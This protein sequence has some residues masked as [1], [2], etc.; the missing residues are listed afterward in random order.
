MGFAFGLQYLLYGPLLG[1]VVYTRYEEGYLD[2]KDWC[3]T[4]LVIWSLRELIH[5]LWSSFV[6]MLFLSRSLRINKQGYDFK[7]VD[8]EWD[9]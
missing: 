4:I 8:S 7:Q 9:W 5:L 2:T 6:N 1:K 3:F